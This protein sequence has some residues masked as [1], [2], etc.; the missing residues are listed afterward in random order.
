[1]DLD[2][3]NLTLVGF[4]KG[5]VVLNQFLY[6]FHYLKTLTPDDDILGHFVAR[7][8]DMYWLD[9]G[10]P[11]DKNTWITSTCLL[12]TL[13]RLGKS[14]PPEG[15]SSY[16]TRRQLHYGLCTENLLVR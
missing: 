13:A 1:M 15:A 9:G 11:G 10:H 16:K 8:T 5:C 6:E 2:K 14:A 7:I 12:E 4:S 3:Y